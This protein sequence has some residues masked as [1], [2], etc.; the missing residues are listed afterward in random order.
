MSKVIICGHCGYGTAIKN[1]LSM[2]VGETEGFYYVDFNFTDDL[3]T[4]NAKFKK[5]IDNLENEEILFICDIAGGSPFNQAAMLCLNNP[6][7]VVVAG[8]N[9]ATFAEILFNLNLNV[10]GLADLAVKTTLDS[11]KRFPEN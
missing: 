7:Y 11:V 5:I 9:V 4:L 10:S 6:K 3:N 8:V 1:T 2:L